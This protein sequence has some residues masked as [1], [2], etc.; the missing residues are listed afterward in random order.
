MRRRSFFPASLLLATKGLCREGSL[1]VT[2]RAFSWPWL[3]GGVGVKK[4]VDD[5]DDGED[6]EQDSPSPPDKGNLPRPSSGSTTS[7]ASVS[8]ATVSSVAA[9]REAALREKERLLGK[10]RK[11]VGMSEESGVALLRQPRLSCG[12]PLGP[13]VSSR[14]SL[15][16]H[17]ARVRAEQ[18]AKS[19]GHWLFAASQQ[20]TA[21]QA[22]ARGL[23][24]LPP[25]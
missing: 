1:G 7:T 19:S 15:A 12:F 13:S 18:A 6:A 4:K 14:A 20:Q 5:D 16:G 24:Q 10:V 17:I 9:Q 11:S 8:V 2:E 23:W 21:A 3:A 25:A 22:A